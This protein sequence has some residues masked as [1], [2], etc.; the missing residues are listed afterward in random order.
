M[1][2]SFYK[3]SDI[4]QKKFQFYPWHRRVKITIKN[5][6][7]R[8][9]PFIYWTLLYYYTKYIDWKLNP[10]C[11]EC[12]HLHSE[13][14]YDKPTR[15]NRYSSGCLHRNP[16]PNGQVWYCGCGENIGR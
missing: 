6:F 12:K 1:K 3:W 16:Q 8:T 14:Y 13:H 15:T 7:I 10:I 9:F 2:K 11:S 5:W 4:K